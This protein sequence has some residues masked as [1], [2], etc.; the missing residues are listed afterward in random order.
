MTKILFGKSVAE[1]KSDT[2]VQASV[3]GRCELYNKKSDNYRYQGSCKI[4][5]KMSSGS[6]EYVITLGSGDTYRFVQ[7][8]SGY[9][10]YTPN[11]LSDH[12]AT[13]NDQGQKGTFKWYKW[14]LT[15]EYE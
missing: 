5:Q 3:S 14:V 4:S 8:G 10:A 11:G 13:F 1:E 15:A 2:K 12:T 6:N 9:K 7:K